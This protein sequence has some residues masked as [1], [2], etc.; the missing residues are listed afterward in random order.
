MIFNKTLTAKQAGKL[1]ADNKELFVDLVY[2]QQHI[3]SDKVK[4]D[5]AF[6]DSKGSRYYT[7]KDPE[8]FG[9]NRLSKLQTLT[10]E[11]NMCISQKE[12]DDFWDA[13]YKI[14]NSKKK[15][16]EKKADIN[17]W[18]HEYQY[19]KEALT[20]PYLVFEIIAV[21]L[22][23]GKEDPLD[24]DETLHHNK[25]RQLMEDAKAGGL[26]A[27][28]SKPVLTKFFPLLVSHKEHFITSMKIMEKRLKAVK[29]QILPKYGVSS[30]QAEYPSITEG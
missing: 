18:W 15:E 16:D 11:L 28:F 22:I 14:N 3:E 27:F 30:K 4:L 24:F 29:E 23:Q 21:S 10:E 5:F 25:V 8:S 13:V 9:I 1:F 17:F 20:H 26:S 2:G 7:T 12:M 19:R 6:V